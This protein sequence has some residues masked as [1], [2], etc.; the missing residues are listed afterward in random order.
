MIFLDDFYTS[1][2][3][4]LFPRLSFLAKDLSLMILTIFIPL[5]SHLVI[6]TR[7]KQEVRSTC[8]VVFPC[9]NCEAH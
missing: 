1:Q 6:L 9:V 3:F 8:H 4:I 5:D 7:W 2:I